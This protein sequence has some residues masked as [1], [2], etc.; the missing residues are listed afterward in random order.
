MSVEPGSEPAASVSSAGALGRAWEQPHILDLAL[1]GS[2]IVL[3]V[4]LFLP[5]YHVSVGAGVFGNTTGISG[6]S[7]AWDSFSSMQVFLCL[8]AIGIAA[9]AG[10]ELLTASPKGA[11]LPRYPVLLVLAVFAAGLSALL[12]FIH[13]FDIP[14]QG[15]A[16]GFNISI[17][18]TYGI[19]IALLAAL[20]ATAA[21]VQLAL[22][23]RSFEQAAAS[24]RSLGST[25]ATETT[26][27]Q[28]GEQATAGPSTSEASG[29][30]SQV[31]ELDRLAQLRESG[32]L[33]E[34]EFAAARQRLL[35]RDP[36]RQ[37]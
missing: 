27:H 29:R 36:N 23:R 21:A 5:W 2:A 18:V 34:E 6:D 11:G 26:S 35:G 3:F 7:N 37:T 10:W 31:D 9:I 17:T 8:F 1:L 12:V 28:A 4:A 33:T 13:L 19:F 30:Q 15:V 22:I 14:G 32:A 25:A 20:A 16:S 24:F